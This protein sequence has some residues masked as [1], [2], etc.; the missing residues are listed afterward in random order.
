MVTYSPGDALA[1]VKR[2]GRK[3]QEHRLEYERPTGPQLVWEHM[4]GRSIVWRAANQVGKSRGTVRKALNFIR[5]AGAYQDRRPGPVKVLVVSVSREQMIPLHEKFWELLPKDEI[6][7]DVDFTPG[8]GF[9]GKPPRVEFVRGPGKGSLIQFATYKQGSQRTAGGTYDVVVCDEPLPERM[10]GEIQPRVLHGDPGEIWISMTVTPD[11][12]PQ[13]YLRKKV[14]KGE[15][16]ELHTELSLD[17]VTLA[18][19]S[20]SLLT[21]AQIDVYVK[22]LLD[23]EKEMRAKGGWEPVYGDRFLQ[24]WGPACLSAGRVHPPRGA[25][26]AVGIDHGAGIG[27]QAA[28]L[29]AID[30]PG[31]GTPRVWVLE[32]TVSEGYTAPEHD[33]D[34]ILAMLSRRGFTYDDVDW[35]VGDR[36]TGLNKWDVRKS[37]KALVRAFSGR[38]RRPTEQLKLI[39]VP[40]KWSGSV[41]YGFR[42]VNAIMSRRDD[43]GRSHWIVDS[44]ACPK[45]A[46]AAQLWRGSPNDKRKDILDSARYPVEKLVKPGSWHPFR[47]TYG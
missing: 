20:G 47:V 30:Q 43:S 31:E 7:A 42:L 28:T 25:V 5:R 44:Q 18:D 10:Y 12:P 37:N 1:L 21:Q 36:A 27:K 15:V 29:L 13:D 4:R 11:A 32:E 40:Y 22:D 6:A 45:F 33:A 23:V 35:W 14:E 39:W 19:G 46:E 3:N 41:S 38:L 26:L 17:A 24:S 16:G 8:F 34:A 9:R 2:S